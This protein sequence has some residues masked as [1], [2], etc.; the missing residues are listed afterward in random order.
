MESIG[1]LAAAL[2]KAQGEMHNAPLNRTNPH[3]KS[4]YADLAAI[5]D[6]T[7]PS[8]SKHGLSLVQFTAITDQGLVLRTL[9]MHTSGESIE[10]VYPLPMAVDRPQ[11]MGSAMTYAKRYSWAAL[12]G[13]SAEEDDDANGATEGQKDAAKNGAKSN[14]DGTRTAEPKPKDGPPAWKA[15]AERIKVGIDMSETVDAV[16]QFVTDEGPVLMEIKRHSQS[17]YEFLMDRAAKR[18][19]VLAQSEEKAA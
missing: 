2:A 11:V 15:D 3:F 16:N 19:G 6:A 17:A 12:C 7:I 10:S 8:L 9:L 1:T 14:G 4:K 18:R 13:I 5:R